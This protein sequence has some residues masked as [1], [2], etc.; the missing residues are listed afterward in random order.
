[1]PVPN[2]SLA[3]ALLVRRFMTPGYIA[4]PSRGQA[5]PSAPDSDGT[6]WPVPYT[7]SDNVPK[8]ARRPRCVDRLYEN[9]GCGY[10]GAH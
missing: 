3:C 7:S 4:S 2:Y 9:G 10:W 6:R 8:T 5:P 1:M